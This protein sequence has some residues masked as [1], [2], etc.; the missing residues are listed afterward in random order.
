LRNTFS[1][2]LGA[3]EGG[4]SGT[5]TNGCYSIVINGGGG[6]LVQD[7]ID[8]IF[9]CDAGAP[10]NE[11]PNKLRETPGYKALAAAAR[12][13]NPVRVIRGPDG[14]HNVRNFKPMRYFR[15]DGLYQVLG[16]VTRTNRRGG[17]YERFKLERLDGQADINR[18]APSEALCEK[19]D[20]VKQGYWMDRPRDRPAPP[21]AAPTAAFYAH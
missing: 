8:T 16:S 2:P 17:V 20:R 19:F 12:T 14:P 6:K 11:D 4:I 15:Y 9:Y 18:S 21:T 10:M 5:T 13:K 1:H 7:N 3:T